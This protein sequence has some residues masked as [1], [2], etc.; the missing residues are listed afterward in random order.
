MSA[1]VPAAS[2]PRI[3]QEPLYRTPAVAWPTL[4]LFLLALGLWIAALLAAQRGLIPP[5]LAILLQTAAAF[6]Q[7]TV[8]H[9]GVHRSLLRGYPRLN[10]LVTSLAGAFL[11]LVGVG[12]A[13]RYAHFKHHRLTNAADDPDLWSGRGHPLALP[14]QWATADLRYGVVILRDWRGIPLK[15]RLQMMAG[16]A[17]LAGIF[18]ACAA[19]GHGW[20]AV[21]YWLLPSRL[22]IVWLAFAFNYLPHHPHQVEQSHNPYAATNVREGGEPLMKWLFLYQ[23]YH[24][25]HHLFPSV[26]FYRYRKIWRRNQGEYVRLGAEVVPWYRLEPR[27]VNSAASQP[28]GTRWG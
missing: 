5:A 2:R 11:G 4:L 12:A 16:V 18:A 19:L 26:P 15:E 27:S 7:F 10:D 9:D 28:G 1:A 13:F 20:D 23:N 21:W 6:M 14:L 25:I 24:L 17:L 3:P 8:L 22:A